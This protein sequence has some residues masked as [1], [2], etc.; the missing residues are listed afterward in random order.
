LKRFVILSLKTLQMMGENNMEE[1]ILET[2]PTKQ[3]KNTKKFLSGE[4]EGDV[5]I[6]ENSDAPVPK[7]YFFDIRILRVT[8]PGSKK[9]LDNGK[10]LEIVSFLEGENIGKTVVKIYD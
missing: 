6:F 2:V 8:G 7:K 5:I 1:V 4:I 10:T 3:N 9:K